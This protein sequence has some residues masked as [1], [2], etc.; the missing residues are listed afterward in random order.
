MINFMKKYQKQ[1]TQIHFTTLLMLLLFFIVG[2]IVG[3]ELKPILKNFL[4]SVLIVSGFILFF[5]NLFP[6][7]KQTLYFSYFI[8]SPFFAFLAWCMDG[9]FGAI[10][11]SLF[12]FWVIPNSKHFENDKY[13][14]YSKSQGFM[15][16]CCT[17]Q[18]YEKGLI[19]DEK[20]AEFEL[21]GEEKLQV[22]MKKFK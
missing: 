19:F 2:S 20:T 14:V 13:V 9:I 7:R 8:I 17:Y 15:N 12:F 6:F 10:V 18:V 3:F 22:E 4:K 16:V 5:L 1:I 11:V 21:S